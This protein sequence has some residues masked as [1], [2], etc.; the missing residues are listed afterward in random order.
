ME[1]E[2][3]PILDELATALISRDADRTSFDDNYTADDV[4]NALTIFSCVA[5]N[6]G[7]KEGRITSEKDATAFGSA[8][9]NVVFNL[10]GIDT[11]TYYNKVSSPKQ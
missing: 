5:S 2:I 10:T 8:L 9:S 7:I 6:Y 1:K 3:R 4:M 11:K